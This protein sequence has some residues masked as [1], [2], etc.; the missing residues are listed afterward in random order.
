MIGPTAAVR[1]LVATKPVEFR[2][3]VEGLASLVRETLDADLFSG[4]QNAGW[5]YTR[6]LDF[7]KRRR[8]RKPRFAPA[9]RRH[10]APRLKR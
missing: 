7:A 3:G 10:H 1:V 9:A 2:N 4:S 8:G 6:A 5:L